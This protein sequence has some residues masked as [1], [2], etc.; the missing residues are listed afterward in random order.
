MAAQTLVVPPGAA[1]VPV[2]DDYDYEY[3][4]YDDEDYAEYANY[5]EPVAVVKTVVE[6]ELVPAVHHIEEPL[7]H[8][9]VITVYDSLDNHDPY[10]ATPVLIHE[11]HGYGH[12]HGH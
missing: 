7:H 3:E 5:G 1:A 12:G 11:D 6:E 10:G 4:Y 2:V 9:E 8:N